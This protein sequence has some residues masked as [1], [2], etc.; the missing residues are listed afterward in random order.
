MGK[1]KRGILW[2]ALWMALWM[3]GCVW[4]QDAAVGVSAD[5][6]AAQNGA[7]NVQTEGDAA[8]ELFC[9][10]YEEALAADTFDAPEAVRNIIECFGKNGY[11]AV[12]SQNQIDMTEPEQVLR[13]C[14]KA[15]AGETA[16]V[17]V[18]VVSYTGG[19]TK[20]DFRTENGNVDIARDYYQY[21]DGHMEHG[22]AATYRADAWNYTEEGYFFFSGHWSSDEYAV[23]AAGDVPEYAGLRVKPLDEKC[24]AFN[25]QY[26]LPI[27]Y[28]KNNLFITDWSE[29][30]FG[31][32]NFYDLFD[33][34]YPLVYGQ[35]VPYAP[36]D[37]L[38]EGA[39]YQIPKA[40]FETVLM[41][42][43]D[44]DSETLQSK[45]KY[46]SEYAAYEYRPRGFYEVEYPAI[47][48]PE[49][50]NY[51]ENEDGTVTLTVYAVFP[52]QA[53][54]KAYAHEV[55]I[56]P[57]DGGVR[58]VSNRVIPSADN[59]EPSWNTPRL[60]EEEWEA[61]YA[62]GNAAAQPEKGYDLPMDAGLNTFLTER[63]CMR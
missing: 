53:A 13:F 26:I 43:F 31:A 46:L 44:I 38:G 52:E 3:T 22:S 1:H 5:G 59:A 36:A 61:I 42:Y 30:D 11:A 32:L 45:T 2:Y 60:T 34:L 56:R 20:Y 14:E 18:I 6:G 39:V 8:A 10:I 25:R 16:A 21:L 12:D 19:F 17:T 27:G 29:D 47:P 51:A 40:E 15:G 28:G 57:S 62:A 4:R 50:V 37:D 23:L 24:R 9:G 55:V 54:S 7:E 58:Y 63:I 35:S 41:T 49:V 48:Y 33:A